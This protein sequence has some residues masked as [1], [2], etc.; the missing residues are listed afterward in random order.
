M[1]VAGNCEGSVTMAR[2]GRNLGLSLKVVGESE[3]ENE[4]M[5]ELEDGGDC[6]YEGEFE[7]EGDNASEGESKPLP[8][9][10]GWA[11][12]NIFDSETAAE[13]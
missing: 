8:S 13:S 3:E 10:T 7:S 4:E 2:P 11:K 6:R 12:S 5:G 9:A 1:P